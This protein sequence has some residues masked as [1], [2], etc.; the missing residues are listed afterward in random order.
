MKR[1]YTIGMAG[2]IDH[3]KTALTKALTNIDTDRLKEEKERNISIEPGYA[4][5]I[6]NEELQISIVDVPGH[7]KFIRQMIAGVAGIDLVI[8]AVAADEGV[9]PQTVEHLEIL[10][11]LG[12]TKGIVAITKAGKAE[13]SL[14]ELTKEEIN[15]KFRGTPFENAPRI[16]VDSLNFYGID[17]L[18]TTILNEITQVE[19][20]SN[21]G[22]FRMPIDQ[23]FTIKGQGTVARG[24]IFDGEI[25]AGQ[26]IWILPQK[27]KATIRS[28]QV[29]HQT[30][31]KALAGQRAALNLSGVSRDQIK[32]GNVIVKN[33]S[34][35]TTQIIDVSLRFVP[36]LK[37][38]V[39]QRMPVTIHVGTS[40]VMGTLVFFDRNEVIKEEQ[41]VLCQ[42]RLMEPVVV[43]RGDPF[44]VRRPSPVETI[45]GGWILDPYGKRYKFGNDTI[46][47]LA[48]K[49]E[50]T[51]EERMQ[52]ILMEY[53]SLSPKV[54]ADMLSLDVEAVGQA[55]SHSSIFQWTKSQ[56]ITLNILMEKA[57]NTIY[58]LLNKYHAEFPLRIGMDKAQ[59]L[60][61]LEDPFTKDMIE[62]VL[63]SDAFIQVNQFIK[64][65]EFKSHLPGEWEAR[66]RQLLQALKQDGY[67]VKAI[68][69]YLDAAGIPSALWYEL[70]S[71]L[72]R[73]QQ[74]IRLNDQLIW[75]KE[76][77][78]Q[79]VQACKSAFPV[80]FT[81]SDA[82]N[83][84]SMSRKY[85]VPFLESLDQQGI[86]IRKENKR[87]WLN[88]S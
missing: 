11:F 67:Q 3:G 12:I 64:L 33:E 9:M 34:S 82:K 25:W 22:H 62:T 42:I 16:V 35:S 47:A 2:H 7:E 49:K 29:H 20:K 63:E 17:A 40:E 13:P 45:A 24:T 61:E 70:L 28:I 66:V 43:K 86:T 69:Q 46:S 31:E 68:E 18:K 72:E 73:T 27:L 8:L 56:A 26:E 54:M 85:L 1:Y 84:L 78:N 19:P 55:M 76:T 71:F 59:L 58:S 60:K 41:E 52:A 48:L 39:K 87:I 23:V 15:L 10:S 51:V 57:R 81:I 53:Q 38:P 32:R 36:Q 75:S 79:A 6:N 74:I 5:F 4:L 50:G 80:D 44:I 77:F 14:L 88:H 37:Y 83:I 21:Q 65:S 30:V